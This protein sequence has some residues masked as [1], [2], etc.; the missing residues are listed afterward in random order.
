MR[1]EFPATLLLWLL[2]ILSLKWIWPPEQLIYC[3][4][5]F[6]LV[7][8]SYPSH[9]HTLHHLVNVPVLMLLQDW[10]TQCVQTNFSHVS[11]YRS[12]GCELWILQ[13]AG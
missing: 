8:A 9:F 3:S 13:V 12:R 7:G 6:W 2:V 5:E 4:E 10:I 1:F 11:Q